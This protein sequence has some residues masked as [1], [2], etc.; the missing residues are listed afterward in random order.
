MKIPGLFFAAMSHVS[1]DTPGPLPNYFSMHPLI[2][3]PCLFVLVALA[4]VAA[5]QQESHLAGTGLLTATGDLSAQMVA[6]IDRWLHR[7]TDRVVTNRARLWKGEINPEFK[8]GARDRLRQMIGAVD[9]RISEPRLEILG[10]SLKPAL[11]E[12]R[13]SNRF[14]VYRVRWPVLEG[15]Y[16]EG[17][18]L[19]PLNAEGNAV[20]PV[21]LA[22]F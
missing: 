9:P 3:T 10:D 12:S 7:E 1:L 15:V 5:A 21:A 18:L 20:R 11:F 2:L 8:S 13:G 22:G 6:G 14:A 16:G 19:E 4:G 17:L